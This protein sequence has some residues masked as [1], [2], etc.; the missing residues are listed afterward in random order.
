MNST[1]LCFS[2]H[3]SSE[4]DG[5]DYDDG[6]HVITF[7]PIEYWKKNE[8]LPVGPVDVDE[9]IIPQDYEWYICVEETQMTSNKPRE[10]I[11]KEMIDLGFTHNK[12]LEN[13]LTSC[14]E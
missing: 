4:R 11:I 14:W 3:T 10:E 13:F 12:E 5:E 2:V 8:C 7:C 6:Y 9:S 1:E